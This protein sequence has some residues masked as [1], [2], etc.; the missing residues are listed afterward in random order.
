MH[1]QMEVTAMP[2]GK[3]RTHW[4][5]SPE[6]VVRNVEIVGES[7]RRELLYLVCSNEGFASWT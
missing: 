5:I 2:L 4:Q 1:C 3:K 7:Y 6:V